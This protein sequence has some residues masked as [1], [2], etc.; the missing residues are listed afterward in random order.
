LPTV[1]EDEYFKRLRG[2][3]A[4]PTNGELK[5]L[6]QIHSKELVENP[7][8]SRNKPGP[9]FEA[10]WQKIKD[11][12]QSGGGNKIRVQTTMRNRQQVEGDLKIAESVITKITTHFQLGNIPIDRFPIF[13]RYMLDLWNGVPLTEERKAEMIGWLPKPKVEETAK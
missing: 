2:E 9:K 8:L 4:W 7:M 11:A 5:D 13:D 10:Q 1:V 6:H 3:Q 12:R